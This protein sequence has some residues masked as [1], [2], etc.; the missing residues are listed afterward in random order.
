MC[1]KYS[2][3]VQLKLVKGVKSGKNS[4][5]RW[6]LIKKGDTKR[7]KNSKNGLISINRE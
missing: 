2:L 7:D 3:A 5:N 4:G 1:V 6:K